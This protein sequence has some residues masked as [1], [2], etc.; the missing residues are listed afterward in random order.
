M[1]IFSW[2]L[3]NFKNKQAFLR[4]STTSPILEFNMAIFGPV[5]FCDLPHFLGA[6]PINNK[7]VGKLVDKTK[8]VIK[9][10]LFNKWILLLALLKITA[11]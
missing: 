7:V 11:V 9:R 10:Y 6:W 4:I 3:G 2:G 8:M 5:F 1:S